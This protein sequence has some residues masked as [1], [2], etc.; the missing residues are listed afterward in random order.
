MTSAESSGPRRWAPF[1]A[2]VVN[3]KPGDGAVDAACNRFYETART[4]GLD[5]LLDDSDVR[6]GQKFAAMEL[7]GLPWRVAVG[8]RDAASGT[9]EI[10]CRRTGEKRTV[11]VESAVAQIRGGNGAD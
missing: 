2:G 5:V 3:L 11:E 1:D 6:A 9:V 10:A 4:A 8:P 7:I